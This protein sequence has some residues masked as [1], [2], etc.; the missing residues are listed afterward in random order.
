MLSYRHGFHAGNF[1]DLLKHLVLVQIIEYLKLKPAPIRY[2][3][4]HAGAG[5][6]D[7]NS[8]MSQKTGEFQQGIGAL[9]LSCLPQETRVFGALLQPF[10]ARR[11]YPGSPLIAATLLREQDELR[12]YERHPADFPRLADLLARDSRVRVFDTDGFAAVKSQLPVQRARALVLMDPSYERAEEYRLVTEAAS[13]ALR[14][15]P[16]AVLAVWYP[17]VEPPHLEPMLKRLRGLTE[18]VSAYRTKPGENRR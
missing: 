7:L 12:L 2:I 4:T 8:A 6:Y 11:Q 3:D 13:E 17:I 1:A 9:E 10:L 15:M 5:L 14:R 18:T 16:H